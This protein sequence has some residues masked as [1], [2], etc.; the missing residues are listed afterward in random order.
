[1]TR[2]MRG[3]IRWSLLIAAIVALVAGTVSAAEKSIDVL[4]E[5]A[6]NS[7]VAARA[8]L[9]SQGNAT[10]VSLVVTGGAGNRYLP[11]VRS[12]TC[13]HAAEAP[14]IPLAMAANDSP[15]RTTIDVPLA[16]LRTGSY[17]IMLH[18]LNGGAVSLD[19]KTAAACGAIGSTSRGKPVATAAP[20]TGAGPIGSGSSTRLLTFVTGAAAALAAIVAWR[21]RVHGKAR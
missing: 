10:I 1:M 6:H 11:D 16:D 5:S 3:P 2:M 14:E 15:S 9:T 20:G 17:V 13:A 7:G 18:R 19:P 12:G 4:I 8:S 21:V